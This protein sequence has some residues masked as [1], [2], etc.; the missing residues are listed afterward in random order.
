MGAGGWESTTMTSSLV[1]TEV[2]WLGMA[3]STELTLLSEL[4]DVVQKAESRRRGGI[5]EGF[6]EVER[7]S[8]DVDDFDW[9]VIVDPSSVKFAAFVVG[10]PFSIV[11][12]SILLE[13][14]S[15]IF[16]L[17]PFLGVLL[18]LVKRHLVRVE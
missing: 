3:A 9:L 7:A 6:G 12:L 15:A 5:W 8:E 2:R 16:L 4:L 10:W 18:F 14:A 13:I 11:S 17:L 1:S